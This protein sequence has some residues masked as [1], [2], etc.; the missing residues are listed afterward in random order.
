MGRGAVILSIACNFT[1]FHPCKYSYILTITFLF[2][3]SQSQNTTRQY[4]Q[5]PSLHSETVHPV[6]GEIGDDNRGGS[7]KSN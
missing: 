1:F 5:F 4:A 7:P 3:F 2:W 6:H